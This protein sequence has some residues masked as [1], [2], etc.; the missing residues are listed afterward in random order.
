MNALA[1]DIWLRSGNSHFLGDDLRSPGGSPVAQLLDC[2]GF[3][4]DKVLHFAA[5]KIGDKWHFGNRIIFLTSARPSTIACRLRQLDGADEIVKVA[6]H[7]LTGEEPYQKTPELSMAL[8]ETTF[9]RFGIHPQK[10][11]SR[12]SRKRCGKRKMEI[13]SPKNCE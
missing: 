6:V 8:G 7:R 2:P 9:I 5:E 4:L 10:R 13:D 11:R 1:V 3:D 12:P